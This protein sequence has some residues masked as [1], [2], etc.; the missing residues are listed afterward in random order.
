MPDLISAAASGGQTAD[1]CRANHMTLF[2]TRTNRR[3]STDVRIGGK[4]EIFPDCATLTDV[5]AAIQALP[6]SLPRRKH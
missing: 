6:A 5:A 3:A 1:R 2:M 4:R